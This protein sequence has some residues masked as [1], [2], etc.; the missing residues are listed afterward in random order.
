MK[1]NIMDNGKAK[2]QF[3]ELVREEEIQIGKSKERLY[4]KGITYYGKE[5]KRR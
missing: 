5:K 2:R 4:E 3:K 1:A